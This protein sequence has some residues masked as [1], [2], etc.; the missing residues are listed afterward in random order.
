MMEKKN[1][2]KI[3]MWKDTI[4]HLFLLMNNRIQFEIV[5]MKTTTS[6]LWNLK[7]S[8]LKHL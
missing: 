3:L 6:N 2:E 8:Y 4:P 1:F 7:S 5:Q